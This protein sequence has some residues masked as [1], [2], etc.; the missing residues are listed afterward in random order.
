MSDQQTTPATSPEL[1]AALRA[2]AQRPM[3]PDERAR[4]RISLVAGLTGLP[5]SEVEEGLANG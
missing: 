1:L 2:A 5:R 4:Q 3:G